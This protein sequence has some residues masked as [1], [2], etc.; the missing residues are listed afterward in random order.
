MCLMQARSLLADEAATVALQAWPAQQLWLP[1]LLIECVGVSVCLVCGLCTTT[2]S[3]NKVRS[4]AAVPDEFG[5][6]SESESLLGP[7]LAARPAGIVPRWAR[8]AWFHPRLWEHWAW[9]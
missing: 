1:C 7:S 9:A 3:N 2:Y 6:E 5:F 4:P 8:L